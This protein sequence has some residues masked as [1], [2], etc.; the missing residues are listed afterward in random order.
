MNGE[1]TAGA[2]PSLAVRRLMWVVW[3]AF[4]AACALELVVFALVDPLELTWAGHD[5]GRSR[6]SVYTASFFIFWIVTMGA[7]ALAVL[8]A[9]APGAAPDRT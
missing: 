6:Q 3:P 8:L 7:C 1:T 9:A 4:L 2:T 5:L